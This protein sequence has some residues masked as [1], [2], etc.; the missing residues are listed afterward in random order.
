[1]NR[2]WRQGKGLCIFLW[3]GDANR[4][5]T[6]YQLKSSGSYSNRNNYGRSDGNAYSISL[7]EVIEESQCKKIVEDARQ[8][9]V[10]EYE[11]EDDHEM[12]VNDK[13]VYVSLI[14]CILYL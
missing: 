13:L 4:S 10:D 9:F 7:E 1:M 6:N 3:L 12:I 8:T 5:R 11:E 14:P 2:N